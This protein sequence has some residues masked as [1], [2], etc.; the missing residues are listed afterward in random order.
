[1][2]YV[3]ATRSRYYY[4]TVEANSEEEAIREA[5]KIFN[6]EFNSEAGDSFIAD[7]EDDEDDED[8]YG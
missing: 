5:Q 7:Q 4:H 6:D 1:M 2:K 3:V 8:E